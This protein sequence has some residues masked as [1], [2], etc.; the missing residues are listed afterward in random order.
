MDNLD[1][2]R[3][4]MLCMHL[5]HVRQTDKGENIGTTKNDQRIISLDTCTRRCIYLFRSTTEI[6]SENNEIE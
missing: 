6:R 4:H 5:V 1:S 3:V 2:L